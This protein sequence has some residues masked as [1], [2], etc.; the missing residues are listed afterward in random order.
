MQRNVKRFQKE[1]SV[2]VRAKSPLRYC[3][4][5]GISEGQGRE[6]YAW[7]RWVLGFEGACVC[8]IAQ[9]LVAVGRDMELQCRSLSLWELPGGRELDYGLRRHA[10]GSHRLL[11]FK[12]RRQAFSGISCSPG[13]RIISAGEK[14]FKP[15]HS[16]SLGRRTKWPLK[17]KALG[18]GSTVQVVDWRRGLRPIFAAKSSSALSYDDEN[19]REGQDETLEGDLITRIL[20]EKPSQVEQ[21]Y[22]V[23]DEF[24]TLKQKMQLQTPLWKKALS[25]IAST[26]FS[27]YFGTAEGQRKDSVEIRDE[28][29][30]RAAPEQEAG[31][32]PV[33]EESVDSKLSVPSGEDT[34]NTVYLSDLLRQHSGNLFVP[35]E[36]FSER[37]SE[38]QG[39]N[40]E[41]ESL[42][43]M[44]FDD[45]WKAMKANQVELLTSRGIAT[46]S[47]GYVYWDFVVQL[48]DI[49]GE[50]TLHRTR[51]AMHLSDEEAGVVLQDYKGPQREIETTF[52]PYVQHLPSAPH[53][54]ASSIS[55]RLV[56]E[57]G[58]V[59]SIISATA[60]AVGSIIARVG[61][62]VLG[63]L[64]YTAMN[65]IWPLI[66][67]VLRPVYNLAFKIAVGTWGA[68]V[69]VVT[70]QK[71]PGW[72]VAEGYRMWKSG[73]LLSSARTLGAIIFVLVAMAALAK[74]T[75]T[76]RPKDFTKWDLWQ[77]IEFGHSKPQ[78][79]VEGTTG[80]K[81]ADV[82]GID[83]VVKELQELVS[84]LKDPERFNRMGTK[85]PHG[86]L[87]EGPPGC[88]KTLLAKAIAGE[89]GVPFYQMA[90]SE[91]VEVLVG[92]GAA[93]IRDLFKRAKVN[94]PS[95]VFIDEIDALGA[96]RHGAASE[97]GM[98]SYNA[99]AQE[100]E[101]T[102]NQL[103]I[104]LD[105]FDTGKG[106]VFLGATNRMDMLDPALLR[107]GRFDRKIAIRPPKAKGR[108]EILKVHSNSVKLDPSVDLWVYAKNLPGWSGAELAQL[109]QEAALVAVRHGGTIIKRH[110]MDQA[111][112]RLTMGPERLGLERRQ[113]VHQRMATHEV[114]LAMTSH[115]LR[116]LED[117]QVEFCD[118]V[119]IVPRGETLARTIFDKLDDEAYMFER[120][121]TLIHR[122]QVMLGG[123]AAE[124]VMYGRDTSTYSAAYL[125]D[126]SWLARKMV[127]VWNLEGG[128]AITGDVNPWEQEP[129]F[130]GPPL[131]F[132]GGLYD[133]YEFNE[134]ILN[135]DL[136]DDVAD[137]TKTLLDT[138]Y[139]RTLELL[140]QHQ[141]ALTKAVNVVMEKEELFGEE[142]E[143]ILDNYPAG[144]SS[145]LVEDE[146]DPGALPPQLG[147]GE[148]NPDTS[149]RQL[150]E[151]SKLMLPEAENK[152]FDSWYLGNRTIDTNEVGERILEKGSGKEERIE[153]QGNVPNGTV[154]ARKRMDVGL[155]R[156]GSCLEGGDVAATNRSGSGSGFGELSPD[157][158]TPASVRT[159]KN[160]IHD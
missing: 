61:L 107:P 99:G 150:T 105:G 88:G 97:E 149:G 15:V 109:L 102:L 129:S 68:F 104:E 96:I 32:T 13:C 116:R 85:P 134:K 3:G 115:L 60:A 69:A 43:E 6:G 46:P 143:S 47:G 53:P 158:S 154:E 140:K 73:V 21:K 80:V 106:V 18:I 112:D 135:Y 131:N 118:R 35:E 111:L 141:A 1:I 110:D 37:I 55:A 152:K 108:Y 40:K 146:D 27:R 76:R 29:S 24:Y 157:A 120:R 2:R 36:V 48:K 101:T 44:T 22:K 144:M 20:T 77:A 151:G 95:V 81:F 122:M 87:L 75:L 82:A 84:Y 153:V 93:R 132:E 126:A 51:W 138:T 19:S 12:S 4:E 130:S 49:P 45:Y 66:L 145:K 113:L 160:D 39:F 33:R 127:S 91:F 52:T 79:R 26:D 121:P 83:D 98:E 23:G 62:S 38:V 114:G 5:E 59:V 92:V 57:V 34:A 100:R 16:F 64:R 159:G 78:A 25:A 139:S 70:G 133:N 14:R 63:A 30:E 137:R 94:R 50:E 28:S 67:P 128:I 89:A 9:S 58:V 86:V 17:S 65:F 74:F 71:G 119:S 31:T 7:A 10:I 8:E 103:L 124:E 72:L 125:P 90:G 123:R 117:A 54:A 147:S 56:M 155:D 156:S 136:V 142:L 148:E 11:E 42:P 41:L